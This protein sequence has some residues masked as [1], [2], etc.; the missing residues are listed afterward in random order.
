MPD[1]SVSVWGDLAL[2]SRPD[3]RV[4]RVSYPVIT[5]SAARGVLEA[6]FW[7]PEFRYRI[8]RIDVA[9]AGS[10][11]SVLRNEI[12]DRQGASPV[13]VE[14]A[15]TQ[16][17]ALMLR[18]VRYVIHADLRLRPHATD[19]VAKYVEQAERH[20]QRGSCFHRPYLGTRECSAHFAPPGE[21]DG[22]NENVNLEVGTMLFDLAFVPGKAK[23]GLSFR[24]Q[25][26]KEKRVVKGQARPLFFDA[27]VEYGVL[28]LEPFQH[29]YNEIDHLEGHA[30]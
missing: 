5:P 30:D 4:E 9:K 21:K 13:V 6:I 14:R 26:G 29:L 10:T 16:R 19:P 2:F 18:D 3:L 11:V 12:K 15:R 22:P 25:N 20:V 1:L 23:G 7:K 28:D 27:R 8:R 24:R 17:T